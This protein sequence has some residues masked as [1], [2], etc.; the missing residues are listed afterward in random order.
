MTMQTKGYRSEE[1]VLPGFNMAVIDV[2]NSVSVDTARMLLKEYKWIIYT[3]K[4]H[5]PDAHRYRVVFPLSHTLQMDA[6]EYKEFMDNLDSW[7]PFTVDTSTNQR[8]RKW[9]SYNGDV[10]K[11]DGELLDALQFIPKTKKADEYR[12]LISNQGNLNALERWF[13]N[14][15]QEGGRNNQLLRYAYCLVDM[16][17]DIDTIKDKLLALNA[18]LEVPLPETEVLSTILVSVSRK[19]ANRNLKGANP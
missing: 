3:T 5:T 6:R 12:K 1:T 14:N 8:S 17:M 15:A 16:N 9:V 10:Y 4:R 18:K 19:I 13:I 11:N 2:E 7:L